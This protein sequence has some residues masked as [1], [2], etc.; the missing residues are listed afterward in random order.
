MDKYDGSFP[1]IERWH[2]QVS[3]MWLFDDLIGNVD[4]RLN[5]AMVSPGHRLRLIA[6]GA[7]CSIE[8]A[9]AFR[10]AIRGR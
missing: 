3:V 6:C 1:D 10:L 7:A 5:N 9:H 8:G 2:D 4:R